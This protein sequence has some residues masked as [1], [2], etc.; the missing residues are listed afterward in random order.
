[1]HFETA[2][3]L[4]R[5]SSGLGLGRVRLRILA[6]EALYATGGVDHLLLAG[7]KRVAVGADFH[8]N[9]ALMGGAGLKAVTAGAHHADC[10]VIG[11]NSLLRHLD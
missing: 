1:M 10:F 3:L 2:P 9:I 7:K 5:S 8:V 4:R 6:T 11:M